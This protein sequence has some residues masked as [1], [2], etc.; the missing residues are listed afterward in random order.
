M[1]FFSGAVFVFSTIG[2]E[3][4]FSVPYHPARNDARAASF[5]TSFASCTS[6][7]ENFEDEMDL[8]RNWKSR[9][10]PAHA[11]HTKV[12]NA[13][14]TYCGARPPWPTHVIHCLLP[15]RCDISRSIFSCL[16]SSLEFMAAAGPVGGYR[17]FATLSDAHALFATCRRVTETSA[18]DERAEV[19]PEAEARRRLEASNPR[20]IDNLPRD[21]CAR[22]GVSRVGLALVVSPR[23]TEGA[24]MRSRRQ[25]LFPQCSFSS[26][27]RDCNLRS[28][29][30]RDLR[31]AG[32]GKSC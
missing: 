14:Q 8:T 9:W 29:A 31:Q 25:R 32:T 10:T 11:V 15:A 30:S 16:T 3:R 1:K 23:K 19:R 17:A 7:L 5:P 22:L 12:P 20:G 13:T 28:A 6:S 4:S 2:Q 27:I 18:R 24:R 26:E 21:V